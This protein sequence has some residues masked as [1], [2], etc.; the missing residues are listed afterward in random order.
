SK[1]GRQSKDHLRQSAAGFHCRRPAEI[2]GNRRGNSF[3]PD[4]RGSGGYPSGR[5]GKETKKKKKR[6]M[7]EH[8]NGRR[9][10]EIHGSGVIAD[11]FSAGPNEK[12]VDPEPWPLVAS[13]GTDSGKPQTGGGS[14]SIVSPPYAFKFAQ[15]L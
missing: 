5:N 7:P 6:V 15:L 1:K 10:Y 11:E 8:P 3:R 14:R 2:H 12:G 13:L 4:H 9:S